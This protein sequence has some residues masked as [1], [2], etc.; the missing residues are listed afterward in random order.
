M[1]LTCSVFAFTQSETIVSSQYL[2]NEFT[3]GHVLFRSGLKTPYLLNFNMITEQV[4]FKQEGQYLDI[5]NPEIV[6]TV[7]IQNKKFIYTGKLF[8]EIAISWPRVLCVEHKCFAT[9]KA[10]SSINTSGGNIKTNTTMIEIQNSGGINNPKLREG[11]KL[12]KKINFWIKK[13]PAFYPAN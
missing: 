2:F 3:K 8:Y 5:S 11:S 10:M 7:Y 4:I 12:D 1:V 9:G 6:D 13:G